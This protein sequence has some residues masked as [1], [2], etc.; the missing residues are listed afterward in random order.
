MIFIQLFC[1]QHLRSKVQ[2]ANQSTWEIAILLQSG[3]GLCLKLRYLQ[4][5]CILFSFLHLSIMFLSLFCFNFYYSFVPMFRTTV[6][7]DF[8]FICRPAEWY[9]SLTTGIVDSF[10]NKSKIYSVGLWSFIHTYEYFKFIIF[11]YVREKYIF[12]KKLIKN[13]IGFLKS[14]KTRFKILPYC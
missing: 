14:E 5:A 9:S 1:M 3:T 7:S 6:F 10:L 8:Y 13:C 2:F 4:I 12:I 11:M